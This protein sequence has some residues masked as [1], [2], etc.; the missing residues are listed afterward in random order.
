M[1]KRKCIVCGTEFLG[2]RDRKLCGKIECREKRRRFMKQKKNGNP[3]PSYEPEFDYVLTD[4]PRSELVKLLKKGELEKDDIVRGDKGRF[5]IW[6]KK[7]LRKS[8]LST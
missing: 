2:R 1:E 8:E 3:N 4:I 6:K 5:W 7:K